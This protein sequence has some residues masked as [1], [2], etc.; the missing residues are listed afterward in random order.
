MPVRLLPLLLCALLVQPALAQTLYKSTMPDGKV[1]YGDKPAPGAVKSE[2]QKPDTGKLGTTPSATP[3]ESKALKQMEADRKQRE[4]ADERIRAAEKA[5]SDA[6]AALEQ[7]KE[8]LPGER[9]G[10]AGAGTNRKGGP[11]GGGTVGGDSR[12]TDAYWERQKKLE[13]AVETA[14]AELQKARDGK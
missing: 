10:T 9:I 5:V 4:A 6:E 14:R 12:L 2:E 8:P 13:K 3:R 1:V 7:G 11:G